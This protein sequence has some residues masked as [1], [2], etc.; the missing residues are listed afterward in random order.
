MGR[1]APAGRRDHP[2]RMRAVNLRNVDHVAA[3]ADRDVHRLLALL[4]DPRGR[5]PALAGEVEPRR[6]HVAELER[7]DPEA[8]VARCA[9][10]LLQVAQ[11]HE[12]AK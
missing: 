1:K 5:A 9:R 2:H 3:V 11:G 12:G 4:G 8:V 7:L 10:Q 6:V